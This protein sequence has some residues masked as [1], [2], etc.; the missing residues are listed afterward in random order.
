M[1]SEARVK[2]FDDALAVGPCCSLE[3]DLAVVHPSPHQVVATEQEDSRHR[4]HLLKRL[5]IGVEI[6]VGLQKPAEL[7]IDQDEIG[8]GRMDRLRPLPK[9]LRKL[10][11]GAGTLDS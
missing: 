11:R 8:I 7:R 9:G 10:S 6:A 2:N 4:R 5:F 1:G 3:I